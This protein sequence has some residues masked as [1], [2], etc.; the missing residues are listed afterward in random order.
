MQATGDA[1]GESVLPYLDAAEYSPEIIA[2]AF[3]NIQAARNYGYNGGQP[4]FA[5]TRGGE[6]GFIPKQSSKL[7]GADISIGDLVQMLQQRGGG[8]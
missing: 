8:Y 5:R 1:F 7:A 4:A 3:K 2:E 6:I